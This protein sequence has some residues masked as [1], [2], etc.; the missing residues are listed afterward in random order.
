MLAPANPL[1]ASL[2]F[3]VGEGAAEL[4]AGLSGPLGSYSLQ[5]QCCHLYQ[6]PGPEGTGPNEATFV[7][8]CLPDEPLSSRREGARFAHFYWITPSRHPLPP[9]DT[10]ETFS[11]CQLN[12]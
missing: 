2:L 8:D 4:Q 6:N 3:W 1:S 5:L 11:H 10:L 7:G 12:E 9:A